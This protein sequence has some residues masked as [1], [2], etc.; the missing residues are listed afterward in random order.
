MGYSHLLALKR[1]FNRFNGKIMAD[2][3]YGDI[4]HDGTINGH[5]VGQ[6]DDMDGDGI[7]NFED[8]DI[9]GD[10]INNN[11]DNHQFG[12]D[13]SGTGFFQHGMGQ[14]M[15]IGGLGAAGLALYKGEKKEKKE[16]EHHRM[17]A[18]RHGHAVVINQGG[19]G[20]AKTLLCGFLPALAANVSMLGFK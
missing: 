18:A 16:A 14:T 7:K 9:D 15:M 2:A 13:P 3:F 8:N 17:M 1:R 11:V 19:G 4:D 6:Y 5:E 10:G 20:V 12:A